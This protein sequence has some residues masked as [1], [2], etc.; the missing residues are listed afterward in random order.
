[1]KVG[2]HIYLYEVTGFRNANGNPRNKKYPVGKI[3]PDTGDAVYK[4]EYI[5]RMA[6]AG[7]PLPARN[8]TVLPETFTV[9]DIRKSTI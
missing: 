2:K 8:A 5:S 6:K 4:P 9:S 7:T 1:M 3:D